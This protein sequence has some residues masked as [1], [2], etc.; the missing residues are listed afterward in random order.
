MAHEVVVV[1]STG[2]IGR[3]LVKNLLAR[4]VECRAITRS[5][6]A[7][8]ALS[9]AGAKPAIGDLADNRFL[10]EAFASAQAAFTMLPP[11]MT[12]NY[13]A[14]QAQF[15]E[16][17]VAALRESPV[18]HI[19]SL[20]SVGADRESGTG[21]IVGLHNFERELASLPERNIAIL[22]PAF[23][24]ENILHSL[25]LIRGQGR[26]GGLL[27]PTLSLA[28]IATQDIADLASD[29][30][31]EPSFHGHHIVELQGP[32]D[33]T[34]FE[35]TDAISVALE[36]PDLSYRLFSPE[37]AM[38]GM[39]SHGV[40]RRSADLL[41]EMYDGFNTGHIAHLEERAPSNTTGTSLNDF[42]L[43]TFVPAFQSIKS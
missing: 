35:V 6:E 29:L 1:G 40:S 39:L 38:A 9:A 8:A 15:T 36:L 42:L 27:N 34:L 23:F 5:A 41:L 28:M 13:P 43:Q 31:S 10:S 18:E 20:S 22:R 25:G 26:M 24:M 4:G 3:K 14:L 19:V 33:Y 11:D 17:Q 21:P 7:A 30:L 37:E 2:Q 32:R 16:C 12:G